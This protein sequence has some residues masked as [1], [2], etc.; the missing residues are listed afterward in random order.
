MR[1]DEIVEKL[2]CGLVPTLTWQQSGAWEFQC[3]SQNAR[4]TRLTGTCAGES[5][6]VDTPTAAVSI[7]AQNRAASAMLFVVALKGDISNHLLQ[8]SNSVTSYHHYYISKIFKAIKKMRWK[9]PCPCFFTFNE[10]PERGEGL[11][12]HHEQVQPATA[13]G[14]VDSSPETGAPARGTA[15][16]CPTGCALPLSAAAGQRS[17]PYGAVCKK[18][19]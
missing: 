17:L 6:G 8:T 10:G 9:I 13:A 12:L 3:H 11:V 4:T 1:Q 15:A 2:W 16:V 5:D 14:G 19:N 7:Q 18:I